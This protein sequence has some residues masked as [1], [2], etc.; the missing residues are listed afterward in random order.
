M[1]TGSWTVLR[2]APPEH[3]Q[4]VHSRRRLRKR[5]T[6]RE[7]PQ[8]LK[9]QSYSWQ[10]IADLRLVQR[11]K[12]TACIENKIKFLTT[13]ALRGV[14]SP[15]FDARLD[16]QNTAETQ[17]IGLL[18][19]FMNRT[20][21]SLCSDKCRW[22]RQCSEVLQLQFIDKLSEIPQCKLCRKQVQFLGEVVDPPV[23][24]S[25][26]PKPNKN[27]FSRDTLQRERDTSPFLAAQTSFL[28]EDRNPPNK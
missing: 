27:K 16:K 8:R 6:E 28:H 7:D 10:E 20:C 19:K 11:A 2:T 13:A 24:V 1:A 12:P 23:V 9:E 14:D 15:I 17:Q 5:R 3:E 18:H 22:S 21:Q 26:R 4:T 25:R